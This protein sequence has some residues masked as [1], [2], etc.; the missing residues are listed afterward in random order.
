MLPKQKIADAAH[1]ETQTQA[2]KMFG[3]RGMLSN[4]VK[5]RKKVGSKV[6]SPVGVVPWLLGLS[7]L[8]PLPI[9]AAIRNDKAARSDL[10]T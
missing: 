10:M 5:Q 2:C 3:M 6:K 9:P 7:A 1:R 4:S 8:Q